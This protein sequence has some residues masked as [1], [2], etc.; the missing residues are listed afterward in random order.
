MTTYSW[1]P[2]DKNAA[3]TLS[4]ADMTASSA[5]TSAKMVRATTSNATGKWYFE[6]V[7]TGV[8]AIFG[9]ARSTSS[10]SASVGSAANDFGYYINNATFNFHSF[11]NNIA[12]S[13]WFNGAATPATLGIAVD[14]DTGKLWVS[15]NGIWIL[16]SSP[17]GGT[18]AQYTTCT[19]AMFPAWSGSITTASSNAVLHL[20]EADF[21]YP[22]PSGF[23]AWDPTPPYIG[24]AAGLST[25]TGIGV[26]IEPVLGA[27]AG[28]SVATG[29]ASPQSIGTGY[30][31]GIST[32][33]GI[34]MPPSSGAAAGASAAAGVGA[35][36]AAAVGAASGKSRAYAHPTYTV[37]RSILYTSL[38][39]TATL[40]SN[41]SALAV[42]TNLIDNQAYWYPEASS[43]AT[44]LNKTTV[45]LTWPTAHWIA[46]IALYSDG[47]YVAG[48]NSL[49]VLDS[50]D[51]QFTELVPIGQV[52]P[53]SPTRA[54]FTGQITDWFV[55]TGTPTAADRA[56]PTKIVQAYTQPV[57]ITT[58]APGYPFN[59]L[60]YFKVRQEIW[61]NELQFTNQINVSGLTGTIFEV[62]PIG[63]GGKTYVGTE[64]STAN[65]TASTTLARTLVLTSTA[66]V[67]S[68]LT[69][70]RI[71]Q[72]V[73]TANVTAASPSYAQAL[74]TLVSTAN[75]TATGIGSLLGTYV[76]TANV[77]ATLPKIESTTVLVSTANAQANSV[78]VA[79]TIS[80]LV[81]T[82]NA[83]ATAGT[84]GIQI[85]VS[86][87]NATSIG[88]VVRLVPSIPVSSANVTATALV[89]SVAKATYVSRG[90]A[91]ASVLLKQEANQILVSTAVA[92]AVFW[93]A[94][95]A[96][97]AGL[98]ANSFTMAP[99]TWTGLPFN[100]M[101]E[102]DGVLYGA[103]AEGLYKMVDG[104]DDDGTEISAA[105]V[106]DLE[107][108][109]DQQKK[110]FGT[111]YIGGTSAGRLNLQVLNEQGRF[112]YKTHLPATTKTTNFR[113][114]FGRALQSRYV[115]LTITNPG[116]VDF[117]YN[118]LKVEVVSLSR[119]IGGKHA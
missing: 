56:D 7:I 33:T 2:A 119:R 50:N 67:T 57:S 35:Y 88:S 79:A 12:S 23:A 3:I 55:H 60:W 80:V 83:T 96:T 94:V 32:I 69:G 105:I 18:G 28:A 26:E 49:A 95:A 24:A 89:H 114:I 90:V 5:T 102:I 15:Y 25:V 65:A 100:S 104:V 37:N 66:N 103:G 106:Y 115:R 59:D 42:P 17:T 73:S 48:E 101:I 44:Y 14:L 19:G 30:A 91:S 64:I 40:E 112:N 116:G 109:D 84:G 81:S 78:F 87:A 99:G 11:H 107:D 71:G 47:Y 6:G 77:T 53:Y 16:G 97:Y 98:W 13:P 27:A 43:A 41:D 58:P 39:A 62:L 54:A 45:T 8:V 111:A 118:D 31:K 110:R 72:H 63:L 29:V 22:A 117:S 21:I 4:N 20:K 76:S 34:G 46:G 68:P 108:F 85:L 36:R 75:V 38:G 9:L 51:T 10:L 113:A 93:E 61:F 74:N 52:P 82:A 70:Y 86:T 92:T 1:N